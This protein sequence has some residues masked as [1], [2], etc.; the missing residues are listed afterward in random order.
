MLVK[1]F[2]NA[3]NA[4]TFAEF[5]AMNLIPCKIGLANGVWSVSF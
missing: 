3:Y 2:T 4:F 1:D 5:C